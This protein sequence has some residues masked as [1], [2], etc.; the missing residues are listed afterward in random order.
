MAPP[1]EPL[2]PPIPAP[3]LT[4]RR[5]D[6]F[7]LRLGLGGGFMASKVD[8]PNGSLSARGAGVALEI[9]LGGTVA[10]GLVIGGGLF[11]Q[12]TDNVHW[13]GES[14]RT[15]FGSD[16][17]SHDKQ[18]TLGLLGVF[19]DYYPNPKNGFHVQGGL[20]IGTLSFERDSLQGLPG[21]TWGGA[22]G[23]GMLGVGYE[24]W[25]G[26]Q[27]SLGGVARL[28]VASGSLRA[29]DTDL[30]FDAKGYAPSLLLVATHH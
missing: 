19:L 9:A 23:G 2:P 1:V 18:A 22:G 25:I 8:Y 28:L 11:A 12:S 21:E 29:E 16:T 3:D 13:K 20:G 17:Y 10:E 24:A 14:L 4:I 7:Y 26:S 5:H 15:P 6:G 30:T 27:W